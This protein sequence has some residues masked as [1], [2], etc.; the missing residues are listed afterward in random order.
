L[1]ELEEG[2]KKEGKRRGGAGYGIIVE[3]KED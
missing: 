2:L 1:K 3:E